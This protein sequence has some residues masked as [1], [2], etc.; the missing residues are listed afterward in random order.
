MQCGGPC[1]CRVQATPLSAATQQGG[2]HLK[3]WKAANDSALAV[4]SR[5]C[6]RLCLQPLQRVPNRQRCATKAAPAP[7]AG[8]QTDAAAA[9]SKPL[10]LPA[11]A[12]PPVLARPLP[13]RYQPLLARATAASAGSATACSPCCRS[14]RCRCLQRRSL[15][16]LLQVPKPPALCDAGGASASRGTAY[17]CDC[18]RS[19]TASAAGAS[20]AAGACRAAAFT[21]P[22][23]VL[24]RHRCKCSQ[25]DCLQLL[26]QVPA[27]RLLATPQPAAPAAGPCATGPCSAAVLVCG[28]HACLGH[29]THRVIL[30]GPDP[31]GRSYIA[32]YCSQTAKQ[33][34][35]IT[36]RLPSD[37]ERPDPWRAGHAAAGATPCLPAAHVNACAPWATARRAPSG[38]LGG[39]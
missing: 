18:C 6:L 37:P 3:R 16:P 33:S 30:G 35:I 28:N 15:H 2:A 27:L 26:L 10:A 4:Q 12:G 1:R 36:S 9:C 22:A 11:R 29:T 14:L 38:G 23:P 13:A 7:R 34:L 17:G 24:T 8:P 21:V 32:A 25:C 39:H 5:W 19:P 20:R 31:P